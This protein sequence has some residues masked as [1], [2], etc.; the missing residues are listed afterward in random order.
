MIPAIS[1]K[2]LRAYL[3][4]GTTISTKQHRANLQIRVDQIRVIGAD[5]EQL[6]VMLTRDALAHAQD[7]GLDLVEV[8]P[9]ADPPV[10]KILDYGAHQ[11]QQDRIA[12]KQ[13]SKQKAA[14]IKGVR[15]SFKIGVHDLEMK[16]KQSQKFLDR[17]DRVK[18]E[19]I[20]RGRE[21]RFKDKAVEKMHQFV[22][23]L[24]DGC[25]TDG[26]ISKTGNRLSL[27]IRKKK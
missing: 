6:G 17:G 24:G 13:K 22:E 11:Y 27:I 23:M 20:L 2:T 5:G 3:L 8:S 15:I 18:L 26:D 14:E 12:R 1:T 9:N 21:N 16:A 19:I 7:K 10:C 4:T 25:Y